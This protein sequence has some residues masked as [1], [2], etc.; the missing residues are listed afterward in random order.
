MN[1]LPKRGILI[2]ALVLAAL[3]IVGVSVFSRLKSGQQQPNSSAKLRVAAT[4]YPLADFAKQIGGDALE[5]RTIVPAGVEP[6]DYEP[7]PQDVVDLYRADVVLVNGN[8]VD[9]WADKLVDDLRKQGVRTM[10]MSDEIAA[11]G[12][13]DPHFWLDPVLAKHAVEMIGRPL[14][15]LRVPVPVEEGVRTMQA[16][17]DAL[18][19]RYSRGLARCKR[20]DFVTTHDAFSYLAKR[21]QLVQHPIS[22]FSPTEDPSPQTMAEITNLVTQKGITTV[23]TESLVSPKTAQTIATETGAQT[24]V[25]NPIEGITEEEQRAGKDYLQ[26]MEENLV[27][28]R[29]ALECS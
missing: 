21:Y 23:F 4:I 10:R 19:E 5:V 28:L 3:L 17:L 14:K 22:G 2:G 16:K 24:A 9:P 20:R 29:A 8:G 25:L 12:S 15:S 6:H 11:I 26:L 1:T 7:T 18:D 13:S 27:H